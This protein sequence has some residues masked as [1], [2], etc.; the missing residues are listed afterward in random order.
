MAFYHLKAVVVMCY[1]RI[2]AA[3]L[4]WGA[5][6]IPIYPSSSHEARYSVSLLIAYMGSE[7]IIRGANLITEDTALIMAMISAIWFDC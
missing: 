7:M 1:S 5:F 2:A 6:L 3:F 4:K